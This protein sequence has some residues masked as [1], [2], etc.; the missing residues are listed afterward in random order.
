MKLQENYLR[1][2]CRKADVVARL[3]VVTVAA[4]PV[5]KSSVHYTM[6]TA[7]KYAG[8]FLVLCVVLAFFSRERFES[9]VPPERPLHLEPPYS[10]VLYTSD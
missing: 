3:A 10:Y 2:V 5:A 6:R 1:T 9:S 8:M 7:F 4:L